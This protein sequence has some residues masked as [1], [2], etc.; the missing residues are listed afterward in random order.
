MPLSKGENWFVNV[1]WPNVNAFW[2]TVGLLVLTL[3]FNVVKKLLEKYNQSSSWLYDVVL[4]SLIIMIVIGFFITFVKRSFGIVFTFV[5]TNEQKIFAPYVL[6]LFII[7]IIVTGIA[8]YIVFLKILK[9]QILRPLYKNNVEFKQKIDFIIFITLETYK[10]IFSIGLEK[11]KT[12]LIVSC[13]MIVILLIWGIESKNIGTVIYIFIGAITGGMIVIDIL[14]NDLTSHFELQVKDNNRIL[15]ECEEKHKSYNLN[16]FYIRVH[17]STPLQHVDLFFSRLFKSIGSVSWSTI[18]KIISIIVTIIMIYHGIDYYKKFKLLM[19]ENRELGITDSVR[20]EN[21]TEARFRI[22]EKETE[23]RFRI[24]EKE[25]EARFRIIE[26]KALVLEESN[27]KME[28][29]LAKTNGIEQEEK[30]VKGE[31]NVYVSERLEGKAKEQELEGK[32]KEQEMAPAN[33]LKE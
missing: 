13:S 23:A 4:Q 7:L 21:E 2:L 11:Y 20:I 3:F 30:L 10:N 16:R 33:T 25:T 22:I 5:A 18:S 31:N 26:K 24:I 19:I 28:M 17:E 1:I 9:I 29:C 32:A 14:N 12:F 8:I 27:T 15:L 6:I